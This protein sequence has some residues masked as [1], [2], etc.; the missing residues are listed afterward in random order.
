MY[1]NPKEII[2]FLKT[3]K[4][5]ILEKNDSL[6]LKFN[7]FLPNGDCKSL[8]L[9][10]KKKLLDQKSINDYLIKENKILKDE[11]FILKKNISN[12]HNENISLREE[13]EKLW[14]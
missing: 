14:N 6:I 11:I 8:E 3:L 5:D 9:N 1:E 10:L 12:N 7:V 13:N 4:Y 2:S